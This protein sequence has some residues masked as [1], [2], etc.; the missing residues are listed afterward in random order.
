[1]TAAGESTGIYCDGDQWQRLWWLVGFLVVDGGALGFVI[2]MMLHRSESE[3]EK[4]GDDMGLW[5]V[6]GEDLGLWV[7]A[8]QCQLAA[9]WRRKKRRKLMEELLGVS[10]LFKGSIR[11]SFSQ[12]WECFKI[13]LIGV[14]NFVLFM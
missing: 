11:S 3:K 7:V 12:T 4:R 13:W 2:A 1:M 5:G 10:F 14:M 6:T 9:G 8:V